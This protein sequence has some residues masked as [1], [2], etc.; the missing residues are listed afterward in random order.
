MLVNLRSEDGT[1][2][3]YFLTAQ[4][5][6]PDRLHWGNKLSLSRFLKYRC[7]KI[8]YSSNK[9]ETSRNQWKKENLKINKF[10]QIKQCINQPRKE[11]TL[12][13]SERYAE[14]NENENTV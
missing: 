10:Y 6:P 2:C 12:R 14:K 4:G 8:F 1:V 5:Q 13:E 7:S 11:E 3:I 9:T